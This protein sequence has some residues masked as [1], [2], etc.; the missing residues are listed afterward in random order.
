MQV[1]K[2]KANRFLELKSI[3]GIDIDGNP[4]DGIS[5]VEKICRGFDVFDEI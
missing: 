5:Y 4:R 3:I 1:T 2:Q